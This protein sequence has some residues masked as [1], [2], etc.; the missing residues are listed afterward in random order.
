MA[1]KST[2]EALSFG[3]I[4]GSRIRSDLRCMYITKVQVG[5]ESIAKVFSLAGSQFAVLMH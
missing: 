4:S 1:F 2:L 3:A 5:L